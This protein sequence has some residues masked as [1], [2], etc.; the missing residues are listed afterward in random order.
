MGDE[1]P[2]QDAQGVILIQVVATHKRTTG[3]CEGEIDE[4]R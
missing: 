1:L 3:K 2:A 4:R